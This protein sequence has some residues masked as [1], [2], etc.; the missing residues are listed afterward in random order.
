MQDTPASSPIHILGNVAAPT[1]GTLRLSS[2]RVRWCH[3]EKY[4]SCQII[5]LSKLMD[6]KV[7]RLHLPK[8]GAK[9]TKLDAEQATYLGIDA[10]GP[11]KTEDYHY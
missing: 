4:P 11:Y 8:L 1:V 2:E 7:A 9:L 6:E 3:P 5:Q 10:K